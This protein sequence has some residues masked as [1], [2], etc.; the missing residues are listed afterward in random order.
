MKDKS[1]AQAISHIK[2]ALTLLNYDISLPAQNAKGYLA[3]AANTLTS[4]IKKNTYANAMRKKY[5]EE[6]KKKNEEW[7]KKIREN[8]RKIDDI[9]IDD[10]PPSNQSE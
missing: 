2:Q 1:H 10:K 6:G 4:Q 3:M 5:E 8:A 9:K 7:L